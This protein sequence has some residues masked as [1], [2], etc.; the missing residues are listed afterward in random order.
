MKEIRTVPAQLMF[1][2]LWFY[3]PNADEFESGLYDNGVVTE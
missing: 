1:L 3:G 2:Q